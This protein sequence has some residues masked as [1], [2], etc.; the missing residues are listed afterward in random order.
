MKNAVTLIVALLVSINAIFAQK[1]NNTGLP[2]IRNFSPEEYQ[3]SKQNWCAVQD[4][5]GMLYIANTRGVLEY[6]GINWR[7]ISTS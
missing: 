4:F 1:I 5:R 3:S 6:D 7:Q 2:Y